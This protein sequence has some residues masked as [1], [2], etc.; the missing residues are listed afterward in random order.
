MAA[1][2]SPRHDRRLVGLS[3]TVVADLDFGDHVRPPSGVTAFVVRL[4][5]V[6]RS[7]P[8]ARADGRGLSAASKWVCASIPASSRASI[9]TK[10]HPPA[11]PHGARLPARSGSPSRPNEAAHP[12]RSQA[13]ASNLSVMDDSAHGLAENLSAGLSAAALLEH[14]G[15]R[16]W[17]AFGDGFGPSIGDAGS[18]NSSPQRRAHRR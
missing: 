2:H 7:Y 18:G 6:A 9:T 4:P 11:R 16:A 12:C 10:P 17:A 8:V 5:R 1:S 14:G 3:P 13:V 15:D